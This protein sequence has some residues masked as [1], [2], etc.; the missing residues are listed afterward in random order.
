MEIKK[1]IQSN[2]SFLEKLRMITYRGR[3]KVY[4][5]KTKIV[6]SNRLFSVTDISASNFLK[7]NNK[8]L[9]YSD[10]YKKKL[11]LEAENLIS[12]IYSD[13][14][15]RKIRIENLV[16]WN[17]DYVLDYEWEK[18]H[19]S[20]YV[21]KDDGIKTDVKNVWEMSR[22]YHLV[23]LAEAY[24][25]SGESRYAE[26]ILEDLFS[27][28]TQ[29]P[30]N[31]TVN[32]TV[33]M[34][35][36]IRVINIIQSIS[37]LKDSKILTNTIKHKINGIIQN[38]EKFI[39][40]NLEKG[41]NTNNHYLSNIAGLLW[42][43]IYYNGINDNRFSKRSKKYY[44]FCITQLLE[45]LSY[46]IYDDGMSY[47][48]SLSYHALNTEMLLFTFI[49]MKQNGFVVP[50]KIEI[51]ISKMVDS[52][53]KVMID[54]KIPI[55]GDIDNGRLLIYN[56]I[57]NEDKTN[58]DYILELAK[59]NNILLNDNN[60]ISPV[61]LKESGFYRLFN[62]NCTVIL[63]CGKIGVNGLG[64]HAHNDQLSFIL[65]FNGEDI[66]ID[67]GTGCYSGDYSLRRQLRSTCSHNTL[68]IDGY[69]QN[70][71]GFDLFKMREKTK[72]EVIEVTRQQFAGRHYGFLEE[73][74]VI[75]TRRIYLK[76]QEIQIEDSVNKLIEDKCKINF[77]LDTDVDI[78]YKNINEIEFVKKNMVL[79]I[80]AIGGE[81][82]IKEHLVSKSY[83]DIEKTKKI[84]VNM[85]KNNIKTIIKLKG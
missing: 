50:A 27:W 37:L 30:V 3:K 29:N 67:S 10:Q 82:D 31:K 84:E 12:N 13:I 52:L 42:I 38:H 59:A 24:V 43:S 36:A 47:E 4:I 45:E 75:F 26:K 80:K 40:N 9:N 60:L 39:W 46:Q 54:T 34:E 18:M 68:S 56:I 15:G 48:D 8:I 70:D 58:F 21:L 22:F 81:L 55:I 25:I 85:K 53:R 63:K 69:E 65:N 14:S 51:T 17:K 62:D 23:I 71:I 33:S 57:S 20:K 41:M 49:V 2:K 61:M 72:S 64:G 7:T 83:G 76:N 78:R 19:Y 32:W 77:I 74:G 1:F 66:L 6:S 11:I 5:A 79:S 16:D 35:V 28:D 73:L 44:K